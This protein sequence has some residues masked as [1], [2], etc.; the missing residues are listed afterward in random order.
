MQIS[1]ARFGVAA[2][3]GLLM[4]TGACVA[5]ASAAGP[6]MA[7]FKALEARVQK[8]EDVYKLLKLYCDPLISR[9]MAKANQATDEASKLAVAG[10]C[11]V[12]DR[13][14]YVYTPI[15]QANN[16][17]YRSST[18]DHVLRP[19]RSALRPG[20]R[21]KPRGKILAGGL[22]GPLHRAR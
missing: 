18:V 7:Q 12:V 15:A 13:P 5:P 11:T 2:V 8:T 3:L 6:T 10:K 19:D 9:L 22:P 20:R 16:H 21:G 14:S 17:P 4:A 1:H